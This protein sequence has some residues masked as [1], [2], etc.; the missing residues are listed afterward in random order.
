MSPGNITL[1]PTEQDI[2]LYDQYGR[3]LSDT[4]VKV[5]LGYKDVNSDDVPA[6]SLRTGSDGNYM[7]LSLSQSIMVLTPV[8]FQL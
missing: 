1:P 6:M 2:Y 4:L 5:E 8:L 3:A 7:S